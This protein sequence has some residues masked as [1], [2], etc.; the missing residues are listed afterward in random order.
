[1]TSGDKDPL[2]HRTMCVTTCANGLFRRR[3]PETGQWLAALKAGMKVAHVQVH[4]TEFVKLMEELG[5]DGFPW[6]AFGVP[7]VAAAGGG[8]GVGGGG[9]GEDGGAAGVEGGGDGGGGGGGGG[10]SGH[11]GVGG[12][13]GGGGGGSASKCPRKKRKRTVELEEEDDD[14]S[15][16]EGS[17]EEDWCGEEGGEDGQ[18]DDDDNGQDDEYHLIGCHVQKD[19][20]VLEGGV[21]KGTVVSVA[22]GFYKVKFVD[23]DE[24]EFDPD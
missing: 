18:S 17:D 1:V 20:G 21:Y 23:G 6:S 14:E 8:G 13:V 15:N 10:G 5:A 22:D 24:E 9:D 4:N 11:G 12:G 19:F 3:D 2:P 16:D 7:A